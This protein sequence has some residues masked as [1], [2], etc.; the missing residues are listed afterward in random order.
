MLKLVKKRI[1]RSL[2]RW[3][4]SKVLTAQA[5]RPEFSPHAPSWM[6]RSHSQKLFSDLHMCRMALSHTSDT[7]AHTYHHHHQIN[8]WN[9]RLENRICIS[10][11]SSS[12]DT[13]CDGRQDGYRMEEDSR[14]H[15]SE[16]TKVSGTSDKACQC[17]LRW[18]TRKG[19]TAL[20]SSEVF[21]STT[22][23]GSLKVS[24]SQKAMTKQLSPTGRA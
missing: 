24:R 21:N 12:E 4:T 11:I 7:Y 3:L 19:W 2:G 23:Q 13:N 22:R 16:V 5:R 14:C 17:A 18:R 8:K 15:L 6:E 1:L 20:Y 10:Q 9:E